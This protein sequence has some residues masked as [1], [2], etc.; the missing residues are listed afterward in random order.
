MKI[1]QY[2]EYEKYENIMYDIFINNNIKETT[3]H[4]ILNIIGLYYRNIKIDYLTANKYFL[5][6][7]N[8]GNYSVAM[9]NLGHYY[10]DIEKDY[11]QMKKYYQMAID[12]NNSEAMSNL[13]FYYEDVEK[14]YFQM[15]KYY[16]MAIKL[17]NAC[18]MHNLAY[19]YEDIKNYDEMKKYY[20]MA[21][22]KGK[23]PN[24]IYNL[25]NYFINKEYNYDEAIKWLNKSLLL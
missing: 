4:Y 10:Q 24:S 17:G 21:I 12:L 18:A 6:S 25:C 20:L 19:F 9:V 8:Q 7:I 16:Q 5:E 22:D 15:E 3:N 2:L 13:G 23:H 1:S 14:D 11:E